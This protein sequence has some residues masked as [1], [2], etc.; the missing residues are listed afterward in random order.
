MST[1]SWLD[2]KKRYGSELQEQIKRLAAATTLLPITFIALWYDV[3]LVS[4]LNSILN[5]IVS[6]VSYRAELVVVTDSPDHLQV[7]TDEVEAKLVDIPFHHL[8]SGLHSII[9]SK[10]S[11]S[12]N[13]C[14]LPSSSKAPI[15]LDAKIHQHLSEEVELVYLSNGQIPPFQEYR[16]R[17]FLRGGED[18]ISWY[19][20]YNHYDVER[21]LT[22]KLKEDLDEL[23]ERRR[24]VRQN[25]Y[26]DAGAGGTTLGRRILWDYHRKY[27]CAIL[28]RYVP[29]TTAERLY[30]LASLT[31]QPILLFI[32]GS[33][34]A[35]RQVD[36]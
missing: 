19:G 10:E 35:E 24:T 36:D 16:R 3:M 20:L 12:E 23:L 18:E 27:P 6:I 31:G 26:H 4:Y 8:C 7:L 33:Q 32:D 11:P 22:G 9:A 34:I 25:F 28:R 5:D 30:T 15:V 1:G 21:E 2:W 13:R 17:D 29:G 14:E